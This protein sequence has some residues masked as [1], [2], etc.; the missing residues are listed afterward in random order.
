MAG[1]P[2]NPPYSVTRPNFIVVHH[3]VARRSA[4]NDY[5]N[6]YDFQVFEDGEIKVGN[7]GA[8]AGSHAYRC[9]CSTIGIGVQGC[10]GSSPGSGGCPGGSNEPVEM[11]IAQECAIAEIWTSLRFGAYSF[12]TSTNKLR[13][14]QYCIRQDLAGTPVC[15]GGTP[16]EPKDCCGTTY[17]SPYAPSSDHYWNSGGLQMRNRVRGKAQSLN[18]PYCGKCFCS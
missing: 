17:C 3:T 7:P 18:N 2:F 9:N 10:F 13:P 4:T 11:T 8:S 1:S 5:T 14:H 6:L 15:P 12:S 16:A